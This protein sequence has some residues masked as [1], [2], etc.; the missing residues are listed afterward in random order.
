MR[1]GHAVGVHGLELERALLGV[2]EDAQEHVALS[3]QLGA[4]PPHGA[5]GMMG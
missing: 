2:E 3:T 1:V 4:E 5:A